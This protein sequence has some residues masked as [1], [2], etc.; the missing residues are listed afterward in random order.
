MNL[1]ANEMSALHEILQT[2]ARRMTNPTFST[3]FIFV[4]YFRRNC[5]L[6]NFYLSHISKRKER[7][8]TNHAARSSSG[9]CLPSSTPT[10]NTPDTSA[11]AT[12]ISTS[13]TSTIETL[14]FTSFENFLETNQVMYVLFE[15]DV[16]HSNLHPL[17][18]VVQGR[19][20]HSYE[21]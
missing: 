5:F 16:D 3:S 13:T 11:T 4:N 6:S 18:H 14:G 20:N 21:R 2:Q 19:P 12:P 10:T 15:S 1:F 17:G 8:K 7:K 9:N